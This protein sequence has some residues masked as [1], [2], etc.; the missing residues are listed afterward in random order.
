MHHLLFEWRLLK[1][2]VTS[3]FMKL[4]KKTKQNKNNLFVRR[5]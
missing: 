3:C 2:A 4:L 5:C 1:I